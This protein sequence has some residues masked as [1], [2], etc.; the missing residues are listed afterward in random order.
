M[1]AARPALSASAWEIFVKI[2]L[3]WLCDFV[4]LAD[5]APQ[6][7]ADRLTLCTAEVEGFEILRRSLAGVLVGE[8]VALE[9][10]PASYPAARL[11]AAEVDCGNRRFTTVCGAPNIRLGMK[12]PFA[13]PGTVLA[14]GT[15]IAVS[16][17]A[18]HRS[19]G[20]LCSAMELGLSRWHEVLLEC[21]AGLPNG[22]PLA[23]YIPEQDVIFEI[24][25]KSLTHR[26]DL[27]GHYGLARELAAIFRRPLR[28][29]AV[30]DLTQYDPLPAYPLQIDDPEGCPCYGC[31]EFEVP[32]AAPAPLVIQ[33]RLHA[34]G[35]RTFGLLVDLT[36]YVMWELAQPTHAFDADR[37]HAIRV[38][39]LGKAGTF[40][41]LDGQARTLVP[42]DL[43]IWNESEPVALAGIMGG[44]N[45]EVQPSTQRVLLESANFKASRIRR[46]SV[47][48]DLRTE[49]AQRFEKSQPPANVKLGIARILRLIDEAGVQCR[50][51]SRFTLA[52]DL[53]DGYRPLEMPRRCL[54]T[55]AGQEIPESETLAILEALGFQA[56]FEGDRLCVGIPPHRSEK[57]ISIPADI[58]E[59]VLRIYGYGRI[60]PRMPHLSIAPPYV[61]T[62]LRTEHKAR[63]L[64]AGAHGFIEVHTYGWFDDLW[65]AELRFVPQRALQLRNPSAQ[66]N[67][68]L[69]TT[70][71]PNLLALV[72]PNRAH[73]DA[74]RLFE[75]GR[76]Y[77]A[78]PG[79]GCTERARLAGISYQ[80]ADWPPAEEHFRNIKGAIEDLGRFLNCGALSLR[81]GAQSE[82]PWQLSGLWAEICRD[83]EPVGAIGVLAGQIL[84]TVAPQGQV[85]WFELDLES[86]QG[87]L[88]PEVRYTAPPAYPGSWQDFSL[89]WDLDQGFARLEE[90]L[91]RFR[92]PLV[93]RR[94]F[95]VLYKGKGLPPGKGSYSFR[96]WIG[97]QDHTLSGEE[98]EQFRAAMLEFLS[99]EGIPLRT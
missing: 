51:T 44:L 97:A 71:V 27:W 38:A 66:Q 69:R 48:L 64:L 86:L 29:L 52:G 62:S 24:D 25:N 32:A 3:D 28:R 60:E 65:L 49:S 76:V 83:G 30:A 59:E 55:M 42:D 90:R 43:L 31:I 91:D 26:P 36:N 34:L 47:R 72:R 54:N 80:D 77:A 5:L 75:I 6:Q 39:P 89:L 61:E 78:G 50:V 99:A 74:F 73:R 46:T 98:I 95:L 84:K 19:E 12:A 37:V 23:H 22:T 1:G 70:L 40:T 94:E 2:S 11:H 67:R 20:V 15:R 68:L 81:P 41:T 58:T 45:S 56:R 4:D 35:Q 96:Y 21:P 85:V 53:K 92:H 57:D 8:V 79:E 88:Y 7:I 93:R 9:P 14:G 63:R 17:V 87:P 33:R 16:E 82:T 13:P 10:V 18:G